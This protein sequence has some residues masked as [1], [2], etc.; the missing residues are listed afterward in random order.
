MEIALLIALVLLNGAF[1]MSEIAVVSSR[2]ARLQSL[3]DEGDQGARVALA[4]HQEPSSFLSTIQIGI[5]SVGILSGAIGETALAI[6]LREWLALIPGVEPYANILALGVT[7]VALTYF[8]VVIG[9][10]V[11]KS[12]G[13]LAPE[14]VAASVAR[15]MMLLTRFS[16]P[17]VVLLSGSCAAILRLFGARRGEE[18]PVTDDEIRV[19]MEQGAEAG[20]FHQGEQELVANVLRLDEQRIPAIMTPRRDMVVIDL[21]EGEGAVRQ[22]IAESG[23]SRLVVCRGGLGNIL[24]VLKA[25]DLLPGVAYG[26]ALTIADIEKVLYP[27]L[28]VPETVSTAQLLENFR[29]AR[30][31][32]ALI[33]DEY[34]EVEGMVTMMDV[35]AA[36][37]GDVATAEYGE[38]RDMVQREDGSW[39]VDGDVA[40]E[41]LKTVLEID[42]DLPGEE[43]QVFHTVGGLV[44]HI[45]GR[46]PAP[47]DYVEAG[48][49][50]LEVMDMDRHRLDKVLAS[51]IPSPAVPDEG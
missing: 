24:G 48:G 42:E 14:A 45:L 33:V 29:R 12:L 46:V 22:R 2:R 36:I 3:A 44:M 38:E 47:A 39:L 27:P 1:A 17:M 28:Y 5:T 19:M 13:L 25:G 31:Q 51:R 37:V 11:P 50:R 32:F 49:W 21:E 23:Y 18:P 41:R 10:L 35:L 40:L 16:H 26:R 34:G 30:L 43:S 4:M 7:V 8:S 15:P 20:V 6:P 9:E